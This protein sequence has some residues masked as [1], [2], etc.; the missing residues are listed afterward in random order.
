MTQFSTAKNFKIRQEQYSCPAPQYQSKFLCMVIFLLSILKV[1]S[2]LNDNDGVILQLKR[3]DAE[4][5]YSQ[6]FTSGSALRK[7]IAISKITPAD[8]AYAYLLLSELYRKLENSDSI[9]FFGAECI[10]LSEANAIDS[11]ECRAH[12]VLSLAYSDQGQYSEALNHG[13]ASRAIAEKKSYYKYAALACIALGKAIGYAG[14]PNASIYYYNETLK[15]DEK[16]HVHKTRARAL[17]NI[18]D[19]LLDKGEC[20]LAAEYLLEALKLLANDADKQFRVYILE[21]LA[22][23]YIGLRNYSLAE[24]YLQNALKLSDSIRFVDGKSAV[25]ASLGQLAFLKKDYG[26]ALRRY[27]S[28]LLLLEQLGVNRSYCGILNTMGAIHDSLGNMEKASEFYFKS[29]RIAGK[30]KADVQLIEALTGLAS[31]S[32]KNKDMKLSLEYQK[33]LNE[34]ILVQLNKERTLQNFLLE[35]HLLVQKKESEASLL[36]AQNQLRLRE[37]DA[38][39]AAKWLML[40]LIAVLIVLLLFVFWCFLKVR[41]TSRELAIK[42]AKIEHQNLVIE[43]SIHRLKL[44]QGKMIQQE[45]Q[46]SLG[47]LTAGIAHELNNPMNFISGGVRILNDLLCADPSDDLIDERRRQIETNME[48]IVEGVERCTKIINGLKVFS[49]PQNHEFLLTNLL[50]SVHLAIAVIANKV[51]ES[52]VVTDI[53]IPSEIF[54]L[55]NPSQLSQLFIN[56]IDNAIDAMSTTEPHLRRLKISGVCEEDKAVLTISDNGGGIDESIT[57]RIFDP[58]FTTKPIG[59]GTGLGLYI[60][61]QIIKAHNGGVEINSDKNGTTFKI[62]FHKQIADDQGE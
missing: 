51:K 31:L 12:I 7:I 17:N 21:N 6:K 37:R 61:Y 49:S 50:Q 58:F 14:D 36:R 40:L 33:Q 43:Q 13:F 62:N 34:H 2:C 59:K 4:I 39:V 15:F 30:L 57:S 48:T 41:R 10:R 1:A 28:G 45:K 27:Q 42:N 20:K 22:R 23:S 24:L 35:T 60:N 8:K 16:D 56:F 55:G 25:L 18:G 38:A 5:F 46:A 11:I 54:I 26:K 52:R 29:Y 32:E 3:Y 44:M 9:F 53:Q 47:L 19:A